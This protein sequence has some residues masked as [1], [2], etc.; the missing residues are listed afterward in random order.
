M[1]WLLE[2]KV[3]P[4]NCTLTGEN[5]PVQIGHND[6]SERLLI[7]RHERDEVGQQGPITLIDD[8]VSP[9]DPPSVG[10]TGRPQ[11]EVI[12]LGRQSG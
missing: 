5:R 6:A 8:L 4:H 12:N 7:D 9:F 11:H 1:L 10:A 2:L 3:P